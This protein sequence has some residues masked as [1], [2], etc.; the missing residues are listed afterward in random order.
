MKWVWRILLGLV[1]V[2]ALG[3]VGLGV[4]G[5]SLHLP[6][7][8]ATPTEQADVA[9][10]ALIDAVG[11]EQ[12]WAGT[13]AV[14]WTFSMGR[15]HL[16]DRERQLHRFTWGEQTV[17]LDLTTRQGRAWDGET[18]L[19]GDALR[20]ALDGAWSAFCN[21]SFWLNPVVKAFDDGTTRSLV[22]LED[23]R[24]GVLVQ[25]ASGGVTPGDA[26]LWIPGDDGRPEAW[27][28]WVGILPVGGLE[29]T[30]EDWQELSTGARVATR[31]RWTA[32][33]LD[34]RV[35]D[36]RGARTLAELTGGEDP[37][38]PLYGVE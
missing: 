7:P 30:W 12:A 16:W 27:R 36:V 32:L 9:A 2:V 38:T 15:Q 31:H 8:R 11:G 25:Y 5:W 18:E 6:L 1:G 37:F 20:D 3:A 13:G 19:S 10:R 23:G 4:W 34:G 21:D 26:Y 14:A 28:M 29:V 24:Q 22:T 35:E 33:G 17:L